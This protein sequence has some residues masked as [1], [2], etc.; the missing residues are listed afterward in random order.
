MIRQP[1]LCEVVRGDT[2]QGCGD[3]VHGDTNQGGEK[4]PPANEHFSKI[5]AAIN[6]IG[7][8]VGS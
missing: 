2:N 7:T 8:W 6:A 3:V 1:W 5:P 4:E